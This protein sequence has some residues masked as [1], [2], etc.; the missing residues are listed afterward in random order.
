MHC[1]CH[2]AFNRETFIS[3][4]LKNKRCLAMTI[5]PN[6]KSMYLYQCQSVNVSIS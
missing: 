2:V 5:V 4:I 1:I 3:T 6:K